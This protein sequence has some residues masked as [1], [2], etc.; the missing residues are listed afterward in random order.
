MTDK[1]KLEQLFSEQQ[2]MVLA[3]MLDDETP[4]AVPVRVQLQWGSAFEWDSKLDT[5]HSKAIE[6]RP[7]IAITLFNKQEDSQTGFYATGKAEL[8]EEF[9]P[10]F[11]RY[12]FVAEQCWLNDETFVKREVSL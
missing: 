8:V 1:Q 10:G 2:F 4:W 3:V 5:L 6:K 7:Q 9:K 11:G 12:R